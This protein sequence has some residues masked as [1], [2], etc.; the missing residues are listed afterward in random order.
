[1]ELSD[2]PK[3]IYGIGAAAVAVFALIA[4]VSALF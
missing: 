4:I 3:E 1:M 2:I